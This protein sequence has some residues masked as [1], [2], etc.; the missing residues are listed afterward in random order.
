MEILFLASRNELD[1]GESVPSRSNK[2][3]HF[4]GAVSRRPFDIDPLLKQRKC[5]LNGLGSFRLGTIDSFVDALLYANGMSNERL[6]PLSTTALHLVFVKHE[7]GFREFFENP[8]C[9][10]G[11]RRPMFVEYP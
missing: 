11:I 8:D 4:Q 7:L 6:K 2:S 9:D 3:L 1:L 5:C 10:L